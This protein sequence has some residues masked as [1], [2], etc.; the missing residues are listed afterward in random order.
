MSNIAKVVSTVV[1]RYEKDAAQ[2]LDI[3]RDVQ[4]E[5][6][7]VSEEAIDQIAKE[8]KVSKI[9]VDGVITFYHF[10]SKNSCIFFSI[11]PT[12]GI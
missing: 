1:K 6:G 3:I 9:D 10:F 12:G 11:V 5:L 4:S 7:Q 8:L 2:M